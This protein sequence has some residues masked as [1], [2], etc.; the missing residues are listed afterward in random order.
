MK[1]KNV[2]YLIF[3][4]VVL[5]PVLAYCQA[6][7]VP[8]VEPV[9]LIPAPVEAPSFI[10]ELASKYSVFVSILA[11]VGSMRL[12]FKPVFSLARVVVDLTKTPKDNELLD[13]AE[14]SKI[15]KGLVFLVDYI[16]SIKLPVKK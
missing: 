12:L 6:A 4:A 1:L 5:F 8:V 7:G 16:A 10:V 9:P 14:G 3:S 2:G 15:Y 11:F 13:K